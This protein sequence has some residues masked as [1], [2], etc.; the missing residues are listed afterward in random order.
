MMPWRDRPRL[1]LLQLYGGV[2]DVDRRINVVEVDDQLPEPIL[3]MLDLTG[4]LAA[5]GDQTRYCVHEWFWHIGR[6]RTL[7]S[8]CAVAWR[9]PSNSKGKTPMASNEKTSKNIGK[10][11]SKAMRDPGSLTK[12]QIRSLGASSLTQRPDQK[13]SPKKK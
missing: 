6:V 11:A 9:L 7:E 13:P 5:F 4:D 10:I 3:G 12:P 8:R 2:E 1:D